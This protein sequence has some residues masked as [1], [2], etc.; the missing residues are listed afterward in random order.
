M[1]NL[2][3]IYK[4]NKTIWKE[5]YKIMD[6][7][8][9]KPA[10]KILETDLKKI[11]ETNENIESTNTTNRI[12]SI[13]VFNEDLI[14]TINAVNQANFNPL[15]LIN[16]N[17]NYPIKSVKKGQIGY[18]YDLYRCSNIACSINDTLYPLNNCDFIY[19]PEITV[20]KGLDNK[21]LNNPYQISVILI[22]AI[23]RPLLISMKTENGMEDMYSNE[24]ELNKMQT[25]INSIFLIAK[26]YNHNCL[27]LTDLGCQLECNPINK[28][29]E[30]FNNCINTINTVNENRKMYIF[31]YVKTIN[32]TD[33]N[34]STKKDANYVK[35]NK[36]I[37]R[38]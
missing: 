28:V 6:N 8:P 23:K 2:E 4:N 16:A 14:T 31:F 37:K 35:F 3:K 34:K 26:K 27:L 21:I 13:K 10:I 5:T 22:P 29:A 12:K 11:E 36:L 32:L 19:C 33:N 7:Y 20:F 24:T 15:V 18:E 1:T 38:C 25:K 17:D 30:L 9:F